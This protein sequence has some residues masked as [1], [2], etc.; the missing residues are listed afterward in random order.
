ML[1]MLQFTFIALSF[2]CVIC[3]E[4][5]PL[6]SNQTDELLLTFNLNIFRN[7]PIF[8]RCNFCVGFVRWV[9]IYCIFYRLIQL[10]FSF[11][12]FKHILCQFGVWRAYKISTIRFWQHQEIF[13]F[14]YSN[15]KSIYSFPKHQSSLMKLLFV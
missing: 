7:Y 3:S 5:M 12:K 13:H 10:L 6:S 11:R 4:I 1:E 15:S 14:K 9:V 2:P 8:F